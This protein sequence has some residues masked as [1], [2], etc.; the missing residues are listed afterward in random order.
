MAMA[1]ASSGVGTAAFLLNVGVGRTNENFHSDD[2]IFSQGDPADAIFYIRKGNVKLAITSEHGKD[3]VL[4]IMGPGDFFG[5][6]SLS[7]RVHRTKTA[8]AL[9]DCAILRIDKAVMTRELTMDPEFS[10]LFIDYLLDRNTRVEEDLADQLFNS[11]EK[12]LARTLLLL[13]NFGKDGKT[14]PVIDKISQETLAEIVG[15]TR[16]RVSFF[17][18]KFRRLGFIEYE[19]GAHGALRVNGSLLNMV[20]HDGPDGDH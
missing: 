12:R 18:N 7:G 16:S 15:T 4:A 1:K 13:A 11:S 3:A 9:D 20:L 8:I 19:G 6:C 10:A 5:Q 14:N 17:M 2:V